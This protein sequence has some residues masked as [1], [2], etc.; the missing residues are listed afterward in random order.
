V[1]DASWLV[2]GFRSLFDGVKEQEKRNAFAISAR[3]GLPCSRIT[4]LTKLCRQD[5]CRED[6][7]VLRAV[8]PN[9]LQK[10]HRIVGLFFY[11]LSLGTKIYMHP[12]TRQR[13]P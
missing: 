5:T 2:F 9:G 4:K 11:C 1:S 7:S 8:V 13:F 10:N 6:S 3:S 12:W